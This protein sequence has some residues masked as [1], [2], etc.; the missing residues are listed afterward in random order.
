MSV[1]R[2]VCVYRPA[3]WLGS[4][5]ASNITINLTSASRRSAA[6]GYRERYPDRET[7]VNRSEDSESLIR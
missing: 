7:P 4:I 1:V 5:R 2:Q 6:A 3:R